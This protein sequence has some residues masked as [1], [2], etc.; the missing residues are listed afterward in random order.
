MTFGFLPGA[1]R[2]ATVALGTDEAQP[3]EHSSSSRRRDLPSRRR[4]ESRLVLWLTMPAL[5][6]AAVFIVYPL[7]ETVRVSFVS[8][9]GLG[10][11][12]FIGLGNFRTLLTDPVFRTAIDNNLLFAA[13]VT[14]G[15]VGL[16]TV[17]ALAIDRGVRLWRVYRFVF[18]LPNIL[19]MTI[20]AIMWTNALDPNYGWATGLLKTIYP[21]SS[22]GLLADPHTAM[23]VVCLAAIWQF[24][25]FPMVIILG[26]LRNVP[27]ETMK[28]RD[29]MARTRSR[30]PVT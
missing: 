11:A 12:K 14:L 16:G 19:P 2:T 30:W 20:V 18:F 17:F 23:Y 15:T 26:G 5:L 7:F 25:G 21:R 22:V 13:V 9:P 10:P 29:S 6:F 4:R 8:W 24:S 1:S 27:Q 28:Q 3:V